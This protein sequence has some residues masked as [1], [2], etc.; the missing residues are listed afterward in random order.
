MIEDDV[1]I[2]QIDD[3]SLSVYYIDKESCHRL[4]ETHSILCIKH[5][6]T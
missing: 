3:D 2:Y 6:L 1:I 4:L 5:E